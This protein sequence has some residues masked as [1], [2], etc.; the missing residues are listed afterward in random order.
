MTSG[1]DDLIN[2]RISRAFETIKEAESMIEN[3]FWNA[4]IN[5]NYYA[6]YYAVS[7]LL[8]KNEVDTSTH[9][10]IRQMFGMHYVKTGLV[11]KDLAK[12]F[13]DLYDRRQT[14]DYD[15]FVEYDRETSERLFSLSKDFVT[16]IDKL[17]REQ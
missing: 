7:G 14:S 5:R 3:E 11:S 16:K 1:I 8:L 15:D 13:S 12:F 6:C 17:I 4:S 9:K 10:G 2:Y